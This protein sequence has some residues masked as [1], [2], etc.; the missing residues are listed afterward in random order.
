MNWGCVPAGCFEE[1]RAY[2]KSLER[3]EQEISLWGGDIDADCVRLAEENA[4]KAGVGDCM[5]A[6]IADLK[7]F[8]PRGANG[9]VLCN[10]PYGERLLDRQ[11]AEELYRVMGQVFVKKPGWSYGII[12]ADETFEEHFGRPAD[13]RRKLYNGMLKCQLYMYFSPRTKK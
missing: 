4:D 1:E 9:L 12:T 11:A 3:P 2:A 10:P 6:D 5:L 7:D 8:V 13:K